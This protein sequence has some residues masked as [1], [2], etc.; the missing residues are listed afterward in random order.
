MDLSDDV[1]DDAED[2]MATEEA[3]DSAIPNTELPGLETRQ[4]MVTHW[5]GGREGVARIR[6]CCQYV[7]SLLINTYT[8]CE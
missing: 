6:D 1:I 3:A 8:R 7:N 5:E 2:V 4:G